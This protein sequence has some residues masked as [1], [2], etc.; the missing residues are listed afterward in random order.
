MVKKVLLMSY[1]TCH[2]PIESLTTYLR[3][4]APH[5]NLLLIPFVFGVESEMFAEP[6]GGLSCVP[7]L[8]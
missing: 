5:G 8:R 6:V 7:Q 1:E 3:G 4:L 2:P